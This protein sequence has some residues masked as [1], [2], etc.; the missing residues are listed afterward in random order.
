MA[1]PVRRTSVETKSSLNGFRF[2]AERAPFS[3]RAKQRS[4]R[5]TGG[6]EPAIEEPF[7]PEGVSRWT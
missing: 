2:P 6:S 7:H 4:V 3:Q 1:E 5:D